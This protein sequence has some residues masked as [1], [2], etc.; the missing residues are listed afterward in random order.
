MRVLV[1]V[2]GSPGAQVGVDLV[3]TLTWPAGSAVRFVAAVQ[4]FQEIGYGL[5]GVPPPDMN[6]EQPYLDEL[7]DTLRAA[8]GAVPPGVTGESA[9]VY[10]RPADAILHDAESFAPDLIV[11]GSR[12]HGPIATMLLGSVSAELVDRAPSPVLVARRARV[13]RMLLAYDGSPEAQRALDLTAEWPL[14]CGH[15]TRV[16]S[17][18]QPP[19]LWRAGIAPGMYRQVID[20]YSDEL[21]QLQ[22]A[23][24][25]LA[26]EG[27]ARLKEAGINTDGERRTGDPGHEILLAAEELGA[28]LIVIGSRGR[29]GLTRAVLG[30]VARNVLINAKASVLVVHLPR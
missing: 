21:T 24:G 2:D 16:V 26:A 7:E 23:Y 13:E 10:G 28:D 27:A 6:I 29:T 8:V 19:V 18:A 4:T 1:A 25:Q 9:V 20:D 11:A 5:F 12:G 22:T 14:L 30:S 3:N 17:V 15:Q